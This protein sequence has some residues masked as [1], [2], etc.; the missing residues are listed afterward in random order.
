MYLDRFNKYFK[1]YK[2]KR[3]LVA[4]T[5]KTISRKSVSKRS[6]QENVKE[7]NREWRIK[8]GLQYILQKTIINH[9]MCNVKI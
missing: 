3:D 7:K 9:L 5:N 1:K 6:C 8:G 4:V 2:A